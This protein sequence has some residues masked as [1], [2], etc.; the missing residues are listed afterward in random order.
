[1]SKFGTR[2][3]KFTDSY[4]LDHIRVSRKFNHRDQVTPQIVK[5]LNT[6]RKLGV[7]KMFEKLYPNAYKKKTIPQFLRN[8]EKNHDTI[9]AVTA[10]VTSNIVSSMSAGLTES[11]AS[12]RLSG[13]LDEMGYKTISN[14]FNG[15]DA[16]I[17]INGNS[18]LRD[19]VAK[20][21][22]K[23]ENI[24][25]RLVSGHFDLN[26]QDEQSPYNDHPLE[27]IELPGG[28]RTSTMS[29]G[30]VTFNGSDGIYK[31]FVPGNS[32]ANIEMVN[33]PD[34]E[35]VPIKEGQ[36]IGRGPKLASAIANQIAS[37]SFSDYIRARA[38]GESLKTRRV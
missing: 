5:V 29:F 7:H 25:N 22:L 9:K 34:I 24:I 18:G 14:F 37:E 3:D 11:Q 4:L 23:Y 16:A 30:T 17:V 2:L 35:Q 20:I 10:R 26:N 31:A 32:A 27:E 12:A 33:P 38:N 13:Y 1:M 28:A 36:R 15:D 6:Y 8:Y 21:H 19:R